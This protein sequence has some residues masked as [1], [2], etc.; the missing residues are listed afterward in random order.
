ML[1]NSLSGPL[2]LLF[3]GE[4]VNARER[5]S[6]AESDLSYRKSMIQASRAV[7]DDLGLPSQ[8]L[9]EP[10]A[11]TSMGV[12]IGNRERPGRSAP[13]RSFPL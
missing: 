7:L 2:A 5:R 1:E 9:Q 12:M 3:V 4:L 11:E 8:R 10:T 13:D 6:H